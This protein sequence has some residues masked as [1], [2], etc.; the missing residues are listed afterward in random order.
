MVA[1]DD[2]V[3][4]AADDAA[5]CDDDDDRADLASVAAVVARTTPICFH[6]SNLKD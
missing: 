5:E 2:D 4:V 6:V 1:D 3:V